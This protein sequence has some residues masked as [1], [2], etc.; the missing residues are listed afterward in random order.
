VSGQWSPLYERVGVTGGAGFVG[1]AV[2]RRLLAEGVPEVVVLSG[3]GRL[4]PFRRAWRDRGRLKCIAGDIRNIEHV[5]SALAGCDA[6]VHQAALR[7]TQCAREPRLGFETMVQGTAN[8]VSACVEYGVRKLVAA[9]SAIVYGDALSLPISEIHPLRDTSVYGLAKIHNEDLLNIY[10]KNH[11]L[12]Y[13]ALRYF[14]VYGPGMT[15]AGEDVEV[16]IRWI[17]RMNS[18][19]APLIFGDGMQTLD[20]I[21]IDDVAEANWRALQFPD[22]GEVFN[23]CTGRETTLIRLLQLLCRTLGRTAAPEFREARLVNHV[24]RRCGDPAKAAT[25][26]NFRASTSL[27]QGLEKF[28][29]WRTAQAAAA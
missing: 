27:E 14:N 9:S 7:V 10:W 2:V 15:L 25:I 24:A 21:Y 5:R 13:T 11:G 28:V 6:V 18:G 12:N 26:L 17:D 23:V 16:L 19:L 29:A 8:V 4:P 3:A 22:S 1:G 20:W